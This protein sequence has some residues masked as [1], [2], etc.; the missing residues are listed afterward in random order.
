M[1][2]PG[3][4]DGYMSSNVDVAAHQETFDHLKAVRAELL[5]HVRVTRQLATERR[6][7]ME[8]LIDKGF[9]QAAI[10]RE[11]GVSRQAIQKM[12]AC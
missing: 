3:C 9:S 4:H 12:L 5:E 2:I 10:G 11:L 8:A 7:L 6:K 1:T